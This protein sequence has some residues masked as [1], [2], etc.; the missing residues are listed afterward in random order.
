[1]LDAKLLELSG[2][3][4]E[5]NDL[6][7]KYAKRRQESKGQG[8]GLRCIRQSELLSLRLPSERGANIALPCGSKTG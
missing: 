3:N 2:A 1:M 4:A 7:Y 8:V 5:G 6:D